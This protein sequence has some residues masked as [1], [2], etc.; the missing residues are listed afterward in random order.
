MNF[1]LVV[2]LLGC[3]GGILAEIL[4]WY[5]LRTSA[6]FP[7]YYKNLAYWGITI[8]MA[9]IGG[10]LAIVQGV[11]ETKPLLAINIGITAP[12]ILKG[13]AAVVPVTP[14]SGTADRVTAPASPASW[15]NFIAGR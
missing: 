14:P 15:F 7:V 1:N 5:E 3:A 2:F 6:N 9:A 12:L 4:K 11:D 8:I 10:F 13:L